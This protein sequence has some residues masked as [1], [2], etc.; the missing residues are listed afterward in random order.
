MEY[1][2]L[3]QIKQYEL[4]LLDK[5]DKI[6]EENGL[7]YFIADGTLLGAIRHKG[8]IPWD[9]DIDV[10]MSYEDCLKLEN[11]FKNNSYNEYALYSYSMHNSMN[12]FYK[13]VNEN[14]IIEE[15]VDEGFEGF[16]NKLWIDIFPYFHVPDSEKKH[17][18][19]AKKAH[20]QFYH[21]WLTNGRVN[22]H[23]KLLK[24]I[25]TYPYFKYFRLCGGGVLYKKN[26]FVCI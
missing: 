23:M 5:L 21:F 16:P 12:T 17:M 26:I 11:I 18:E 20:K 3:K 24:K 1:L 7:R 25:F 6:C 2:T 9:D 8:F 15:D 19:V 13:L 10:Y 4:K 14:V 22:N